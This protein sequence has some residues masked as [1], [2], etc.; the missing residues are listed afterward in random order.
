MNSKVPISIQSISIFNVKI[1]IIQT[2]SGSILI[3]TGIPFQEKRISRALKELGV[4]PREIKLILLTHGHLDHI[5]CLFYLKEING[6]EIVCHQ[7]IAALLE[8]GSYE[9]AVPRTPSVEA[10]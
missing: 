3:D 1:F 8:K 6:A 10:I 5:G 4:D 9:E 2:Q 7:S